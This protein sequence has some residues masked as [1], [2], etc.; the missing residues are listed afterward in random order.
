MSRRNFQILVAGSQILVIGIVVVQY[1]TDSSLPAEL[2]VH[3]T[4][5]IPDRYAIIELLTDIPFVI[6]T[7][8]GLFAAVGLILFRTWGRPVFLVYVV[9]ELVVVLLTGPHVSTSWTAFLGYIYSI[10]EGV[11]LALIYFSPIRKM[12][13]AQNEI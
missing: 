13:G 4:L 8:L 3:G 1:V 10:A 12:F 5:L 9:T 2:R 11:I 6:Q 7:L